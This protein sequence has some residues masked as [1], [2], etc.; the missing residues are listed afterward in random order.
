VT[1]GSDS[2]GVRV[3]RHDLLLHLIELSGGLIVGTS[4]NISGK[5]PSRTALEAMREIGDKVDIIL[6]GGETPIGISST[7]LDLTSDLPRIL[8]KGPIKAGEILDVLRG[9]EGT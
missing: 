5:K 4:A 1:C 2:V 6:D 7:V 9:L 8:R 3:P